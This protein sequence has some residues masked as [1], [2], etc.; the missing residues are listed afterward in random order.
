MDT[1][2]LDAIQLPCHY[3]RELKHGNTVQVRGSLFLAYE[4]TDRN[5]QRITSCPTLPNAAD[6]LMQQ[7]CQ[8][9]HA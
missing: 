6:V 1:H 4:E 5:G 2:L 7:P 3:S 9:L 8:Q